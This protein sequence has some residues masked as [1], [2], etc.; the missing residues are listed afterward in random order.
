MQ[1]LSSVLITFQYVSPFFLREFIVNSFKSSF[2]VFD[3]VFFRQKFYILKGLG[4]QIELKYF[5]EIDTRI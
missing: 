1:N 4:H 2:R 5:D 3:T